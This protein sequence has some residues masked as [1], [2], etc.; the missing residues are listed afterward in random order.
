MLNKNSVALLAL[1]HLGATSHIIDL[2]TDNTTTAKVINRHLQTSL[3]TAVEAFEW[4]FLNKEQALTLITSNP[5]TQWGFE[6]SYPSDAQV[7]RELA[8]EACFIKNVNLYPE[9]KIPWQDIYDVSHTHLYCDLSQAWARY[10]KTV[11]VSDSVPNHFGRYWAGQLAKDIAP[12]IITNNF[13]K[14]KNVFEGQ[15]ERAMDN[16]IA[17]DLTR[18]PENSVVIPRFI[19]A[20]NK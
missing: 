6:Y 14:V 18:S 9:Q 12:S 5:T 17:T 3:E 13:A 11:L 7:I 20:R 8:Q 19:A 1:G 2:D 16:A 15:V 10:T 4:A